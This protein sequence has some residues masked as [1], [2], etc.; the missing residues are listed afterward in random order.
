MKIKYSDMFFLSTLNCILWTLLSSDRYLY[1]GL[2]FIYILNSI[3][4]KYAR[5]YNSKDI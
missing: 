5:W 3:K 1:V 2:A 4:K